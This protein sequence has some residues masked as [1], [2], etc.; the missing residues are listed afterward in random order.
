MVEDESIFE[1]PAK[2]SVR[3]FVSG[4]SAPGPQQRL[5]PSNASVPATPAT[6]RHPTYIRPPPL[7]VHT[8]YELPAA[9]TAGKLALNIGIA[10]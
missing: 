4:A 10:C 2:P 3:L 6:R 8:V 9:G 7:D 1:D 5:G